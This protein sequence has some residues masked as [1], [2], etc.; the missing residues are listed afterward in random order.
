MY[1]KINVMHAHTNT[2]VGS[3]HDLT[4]A[5]GMY[6]QMAIE[7]NTN[8]KLLLVISIT[9]SNDTSILS[10]IWRYEGCE[11]TEATEENKGQYGE[12]HDATSPQG[13]YEE[14]NNRLV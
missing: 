5:N 4:V 11:E 12:F 10:K 6:F 3:D 1:P 9:Q 14:R 2:A 7:P 8:H 13:R